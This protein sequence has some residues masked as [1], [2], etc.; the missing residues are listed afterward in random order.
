MQKSGKHLKGTF[1]IFMNSLPLQRAMNN[2]NKIC[3][4]NIHYSL[5]GIEK[6][7]RCLTNPLIRFTEVSTN[8]LSKIVFFYPFSSSQI[9]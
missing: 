5:S 3:K 6:L 7:Q 1:N 9:I 4:L 8:S 2:A